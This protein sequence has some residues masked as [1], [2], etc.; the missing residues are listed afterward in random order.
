MRY[1]RGGIRF[2]PVRRCFLCNEY[3][4]Y[5]YWADDESALREEL[6]NNQ[7]EDRLYYE[8][9]NVYVEQLNEIV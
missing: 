5:E 8:N 7:Y 3:E 2:I 9:G 6:H 1:N 4:E